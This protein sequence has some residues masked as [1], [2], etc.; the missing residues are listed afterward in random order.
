[1]QGFNFFLFCLSSLLEAINSYSARIF[2]PSNN[3]YTPT[4]IDAFL[5]VAQLIS[6]HLKA[7]ELE[8]LLN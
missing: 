4:S 1:M 5:L 3:I 6:H 2:F 8:A 7:G